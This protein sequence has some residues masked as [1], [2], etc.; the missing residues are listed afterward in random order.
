MIQDLNKLFKDAYCCD[1]PLDEDH[2]LTYYM[3]FENSFCY[4]N[5]IMG[6]YKV[7]LQKY[8]ITHGGSL[9]MSWGYSSTSTMHEEE[10]N[11]KENS[12]NYRILNKKLLSKNCY[13]KITG[14]IT[15]DKVFHPTK[16]EHAWCI[17]VKKEIEP[18]VDSFNLLAGLIKNE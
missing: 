2:P 3:D 17:G 11:E 8:G 10:L 1:D 7:T 13:Y 16:K 12:S 4:K 14:K 6:T 5:K 9:D 15:S 18:P